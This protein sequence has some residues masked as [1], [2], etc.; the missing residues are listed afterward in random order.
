MGIVQ[1]TNWKISGSQAA[2]FQR[3]YAQNG[4]KIALKWLSEE[5][6]RVTK[7]MILFEFISQKV[8]L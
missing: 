1:A 2:F 5:I 7:A 8:K 6:S 4:S 3:F